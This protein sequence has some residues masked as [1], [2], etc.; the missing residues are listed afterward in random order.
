MTSF[1]WLYLRPDSEEYVYEMWYYKALS[2]KKVFSWVTKLKKKENDK[3]D[4]AWV[5]RKKTNKNKINRK[6][7]STISVNAQ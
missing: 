7:L 5:M 6:S 4:L 3:Q 2:I 1:P